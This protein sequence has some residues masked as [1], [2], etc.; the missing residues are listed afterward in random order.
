MPS[1]NPDELSAI[2]NNT[3]VKKTGGTSS[4]HNSKVSNNF[5]NPNFLREQV[6]DPGQAGKSRD[7]IYSTLDSLVLAPVS[8]SGYERVSEENHL[9]VQALSVT[10]VGTLRV[11]RGDV[12]IYCRT[13]VVAP[14]PSDADNQ[15]GAT[16]DVSAAELAVPYDQPSK[17]ATPRAADGADGADGGAMLPDGKLFGHQG[18]AGGRLRD[19]AAGA[20]VVSTISRQPALPRLNPSSETS[21]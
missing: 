3:F 12:K 15:L 16:I 1:A 6:A 17:P 2:K 13:L 7:R 5:L 10:L 4:F 9:T 18:D 20:Y 14:P 8:G 19:K 11:P 21:S